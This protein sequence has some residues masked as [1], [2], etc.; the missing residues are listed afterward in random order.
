MKKDIEGQISIIA[1]YPDAAFYSEAVTN[2]LENE[3]TMNRRKVAPENTN[4]GKY[5]DLFTKYVKRIT[6]RYSGANIISATLTRTA[7]TN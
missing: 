6:A 7:S 4:A 1:G 3:L 2:I 5:H